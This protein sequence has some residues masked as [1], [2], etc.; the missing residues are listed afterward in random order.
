MAEEITPSPVDDLNSA[1]RPPSQFSIWKLIFAIPWWAV[2]IVISGLIIFINIQNNEIYATAFS[3]LSEGI[4]VTARVT[5][6]SFGGGLILGAII[7]IIRSY[8]PEPGVGLVDGIINLIHLAIYNAATVFV[9]IMRGLPIVVVLLVGAYILTP[10]INRFI[11]ANIDPNFRIRG[12]SI[13]TAI[14]AFTLAYGAFLSEIFRAGIQ[15]VDKG[16]IEASKS[17]GMSSGQTMRFIILPQAIRRMIPPLGNDFI[18]MIKDSSLV[19]ILAVRDVTQI[20]K[21]QSGSSFRVTEVYLTVAFIYLVLTFTGSLLVRAIEN[22]TNG[23][24][25]NSPF[26]RL[27][28]R[29]KNIIKARPTA[30]SNDISLNGR[31]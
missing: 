6:F 19:A 4:S 24:V 10:E 20:A 18:A 7:G 13:E 29:L 30:Q 5:F 2:F 23:E 17:L 31:S 14:I 28:V 22:R 21:I 16:Q 27:L 12:Q 8:K 9:E 26:D 15:S 11:Q 25:K 3:R 1:R